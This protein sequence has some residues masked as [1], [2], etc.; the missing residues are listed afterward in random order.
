[1]PRTDSVLVRP[2]RD[3][4]EISV[5]FTHVVKQ[6]VQEL[7]NCGGYDGPRE[8]CRGPKSEEDVVLDAACHEQLGLDVQEGQLY[9]LQLDLDEAKNCRLQCLVQTFTGKG[10]APC[11]VV[12]IQD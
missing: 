5:R 2:G 11:P 10:D 12:P 9:V 6:M 1:M 4:L 8:G 3:K 7:D